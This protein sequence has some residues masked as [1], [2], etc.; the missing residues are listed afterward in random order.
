MRNILF[1]VTLILTLK[2]SSQ[3]K[4]EIKKLLSPIYKNHFIINKGYPIRSLDSFDLI[5]V[6]ETYSELKEEILVPDS[7]ILEL[8]NKKRDSLINNKWTYSFLPECILVQDENEILDSRK[9]LKLKRI[10]RK[11]E[12]GKIFI[13]QIKKWNNT[14]FLEKTIY[15]FSV[16]VFDKSNTYALVSYGYSSNPLS[17]HSWVL[18][19]K[20]ENGVWVEKLII[21]R[22]VS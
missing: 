6:K 18:L 9:I 2:A 17:G 10:S 19:Y 4:D 16:P 11:S 20:L 8:F 12:S 3:N 13:T 22:Y 14:P 7:I 21:K 1:I 5:Q 15:S